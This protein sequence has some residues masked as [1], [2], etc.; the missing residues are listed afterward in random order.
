[1]GR[2]KGDERQSRGIALTVGMFVGILVFWI[3]LL[4]SNDRPAGARFLDALIFGCV[5]FLLPY[6]LYLSSTVVEAA[7]PAAAAA[8]AVGAAVEVGAV[9]VIS[10]TRTQPSQVFRSCASSKAGYKSTLLAFIRR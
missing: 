1:M 7:I 4:V 2:G 10:H 9:V 5:G 3:V 8:A 6:G